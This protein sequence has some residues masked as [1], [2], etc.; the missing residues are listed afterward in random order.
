MKRSIVKLL[1]ALIAVAIVAA[2]TSFMVN[3]Y[4]NPGQLDVLTAQAM[5]MSAM[6][7]PTGAAP[8]A[9]TTVRMGS[10][11]DSVTYTGSIQALNTQ[12]IAARVAGTITALSVY[13][14]DRVRA[15]QVLVRLDSAELS[16]KHAEASANAR[17]ADFSAQAAWS[18]H[19][20]HHQ[21]ALDQAHD[22]SAS[23]EQSI[24]D[25]EG[26]E[27]AAKEEIAGAQA[28]SDGVRANLEYWKNEIAREKK[29]YDA[30]AVSL[31]EYQQEQSQFTAAQSAV[32][33]ADAKIRTAQANY[34]AAMARTSKA[35]RDLMTAQSGERLANADIVLARQQAMK[36]TA[37]ADSA[38]AAVTEASVIQGYT[39]LR[40]PASGVVVERPVAPGSLVQPGTVIVRVA[41]IDKV[42]VQANVAVTDMAGIHVGS[43][44]RVSPQGGAP[45]SARVTAVFPAANDQSRTAV[46]EA[47]IANPGGRLLPGG[48]VSIAITRD[49]HNQ[50]MLV[51]SGSLV[52]SGDGSYVWV[53]RPVALSAS[54]Q[55][56]QYECTKCHMRY[57]AADAKKY[58]YIDP[59]DGGKLVPFTGDAQAATSA[60]T[61][62]TAHRVQVTPGATDGVS[63]AVTSP[64]LLEGDRVVK[65]GMAGLTE[66]AQ[67]VQTAWNSSGPV[68]T[69][70]PAATGTRY[71]CDKCGMIYSA[72]DAK[73]Y[74][75]KDPMDGGNLVAVA[76]DA[77]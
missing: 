69:A 8:V 44:L 41:Q 58:N 24:R 43:P 77:K 15:G 5:D 20:L 38:R 55:P 68:V 53:A 2:I 66:G 33:E 31:S 18:N 52:T 71:K 35:R 3:R 37:G 57:S 70:K 7:P 72:A 50:A 28:A 13:P 54:G 76:G 75:F 21:F 61:S 62:W 27:A 65:L 59:M 47:L 12:D 29:L 34:R 1:A 9:L 73:K 51:P 64:E 30:G 10:V 22:V 14:G 19:H 4:R 16:A 48:Y 42:R 49:V 23:A 60:S 39:E 74:N 45:L 36:E 25:A 6:R 40:A 26:S 67:L 46:V 56:S 63:T 17:Q 11:A 32:D